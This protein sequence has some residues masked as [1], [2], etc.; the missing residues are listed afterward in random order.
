MALCKYEMLTHVG[1][2]VPTRFA[3]QNLA[4]EAGV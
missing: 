1:D 2:I 4:G 3:M